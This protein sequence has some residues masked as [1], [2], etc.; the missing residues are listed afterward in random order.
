MILS[1]TSD[2]MSVT[3]LNGVVKAR[4][5]AGIHMNTSTENNG[6]IPRLLFQKKDL[7]DASFAIKCLVPKS[8]Q[9]IR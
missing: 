4:L 2:K 9:G 7:E 1:M 3:K 5:G 6:W 8:F